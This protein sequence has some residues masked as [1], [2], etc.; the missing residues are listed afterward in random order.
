MLLKNLNIGKNKSKIQLMKEEINDWYNFHKLGFVELENRGGEDE[1][2]CNF[3]KML[4]LEQYKSPEMNALYQKVIVS[5]PLDYIENLL[6]EM[7]KERNEHLPSHHALAIEFYSPFYM[8]LSMSDAAEGKE[9][10][11]EIAQSYVRYMNAFF[12]KYFS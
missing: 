7:S 1:I 11:D 5:G 2:A 12:Q 9:E 4:T 8:L 6:R 10:K 3:R